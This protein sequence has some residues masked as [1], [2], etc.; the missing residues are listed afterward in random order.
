VALLSLWYL[1]RQ[2]IAAVHM[3]GDSGAAALEGLTMAV[4][5]V[6]GSYIIEFL[7]NWVRE[8]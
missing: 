7:I 5:G 4:A 1:Q 8:R 3:T 2:G 6:G